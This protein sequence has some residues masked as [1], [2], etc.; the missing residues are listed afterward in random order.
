MFS[1]IDNIF[2][3]KFGLEINNRPDYYSRKY[4][5]FYEKTRAIWSEDEEPLIIWQLRH[6][7]M[8]SVNL[9]EITFERT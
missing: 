8:I 9:E 7:S 6:L 1:K 5:I 4:G 3:S 2:S